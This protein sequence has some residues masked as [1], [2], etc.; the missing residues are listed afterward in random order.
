MV[1]GMRNATGA[2]LLV[3]SLVLTVYGL[4]DIWHGPELAKQILRTVLLAQVLLSLGL[5]V[6]KK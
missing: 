5:W 3:M 4:I 6:L 1:V 2:N